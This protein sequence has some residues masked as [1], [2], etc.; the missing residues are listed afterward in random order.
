MDSF[1][2]CEKN[3]HKIC[4]QKKALSNLTKDD[5]AS[6]VFSKWS[7]TYS[8]RHIKSWS[9][10]QKD[11]PT[12]L[13]KILIP[14]SSQVNFLFWKVFFLLATEKRSSVVNV[15]EMHFANSRFICNICILYL[16]Y[17][18]SL[19]IISAFDGCWLV[20]GRRIAQ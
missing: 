16:C 5:C 1:V 18:H 4:P 14:S 8:Y 9:S 6:D 20:S 7:K 15:F 3:D 11:P 19:N 17:L 12:Y 2:D 10:R 13:I